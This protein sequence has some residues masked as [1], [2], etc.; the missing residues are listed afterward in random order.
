MTFTPSLE[1]D[2]ARRDFTVNAM[3]YRPG[4]GLVD[5]YGGRRDLAARLIRCVGEPERR[6]EEDALRILRAYRFVSK[7]DFALEEETGVWAQR[8]ADR[9]EKVS[10]ERIYGE[11][12]GILLGP[13]AGRAVREMGHQV[14][15]QIFPQREG[16]PPGQFLS[17]DSR[18]GADRLQE[19]AEA[20]GRA[21]QDFPLRCALLLR[22]L[23]P[24]ESLSEESQREAS[25]R[26]IQRLLKQRCFPSGTAGEIAALFRFGERPLLAQRIS[27]LRLLQEAGLQTVEQLIALREALTGDGD[28]SSLT[29]VRQRLS[30][31]LAGE[32]NA[33]YTVGQLAVG[34][35]ELLQAGIPPGRPLGEALHRLLEAVIVGAADN[36]PEGLIDYL[37]GEGAA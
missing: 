5:L 8:L 21:E 2:L 17:D 31:L 9:L 16:F 6:F 23:F 15:E 1:E 28:I 32:K 24:P 35:R 7:L 33:C 29:A 19:T 13:A 12:R 3:A 26:E 20:V 11:V 4:T 14:L 18:E 10:R 37:E 27:L 22:L 30:Q 25:A 36:T 34:G